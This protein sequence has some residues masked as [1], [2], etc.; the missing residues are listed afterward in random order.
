MLGRTEM[1]V[2]PQIH[3]AIF[4]VILTG[5][6]GACEIGYKSTTIPTTFRAGEQDPTQ[7]TIQVPDEITGEVIEEPNIL[8][9]DLQL[10][11][12]VH[13][14]YL[15]DHFSLKQLITP[16]GFRDTDFDKASWLGRKFN[17][18]IPV[19]IKE[20]KLEKDFKPDGEPE[21]FSFHTQGRRGLPMSEEVHGILIWYRAADFDAKIFNPE[22]FRKIIFING[23]EREVRHEDSPHQTLGPDGRLTADSQLG[24]PIHVLSLRD[25]TD[26]SRPPSDAQLIEGLAWELS[27]G[28]SQM[29]VH[30]DRSI[31]QGWHDRNRVSPTDIEKWERGEI[32]ASIPVDGNGDELFGGIKREGMKV[33]NFQFDEIIN[34]DIRE[35]SRVGFNQAGANTDERKSATEQSIVENNFQAGI[36]ADR[37]RVLEWFLIGVER[38]FLPLVQRYGDPQFFAKFVGE[39][40]AQLLEQWRSSPLPARLAFEVF[41]DSG[42]HIDAQVKLDTLMRIYEFTAKDPN[43]NRVPILRE[44]IGLASLNASEVV[45]E[46]LPEAKPQPPNIS[47]RISGDDM[48]P[49]MPQFPVLLE[50]LQQ[51]GLK[52]SQEAIQRGLATN[53]AMLITQA[54][55]GEQ[56]AAAANQDGEHKGLQPKAELLSKRESESEDQ[57][58]LQMQGAPEGVQ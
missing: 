6:L 15:W 3:K 43:V 5:G 10:D 31:P 34:R 50:I 53:D 30:R 27:K 18:P 12:P 48:N 47:A 14:E 2:L 16:K 17:M 39:Q 45:V 26:S 13:E 9:S 20:F 49:A 7:P 56:E 57:A 25:V 32:G 40:G 38:K 28:R 1:N 44:I 51:L 35:I 21:D 11:I 23:M 41:P 33:E 54:L 24:N 46:E 37:N 29:L 8:Q 55:L 36:D 52:I 19:A 58:G 42:A 4:D 22:L